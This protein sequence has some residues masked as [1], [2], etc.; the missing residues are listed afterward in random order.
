MSQSFYTRLARRYAP[1]RFAV[2]RRDLLKATLAASAG[3]LLS[4][5]NASNGPTIPW[6][7]R[8]VI[9]IGAGFAGLACAYELASVGY[10]VTVLEARNR[11]G[12][13]VLSFTDMVKG[14]VVEGGGELIGTNH[15]TWVNYEAKFHL[16]FTEIPD[17]KDAE[18]PLLLEGRLLA[19]DE[20]KKIFDEIDAAMSTLNDAARRVNE[21]QPWKT[22]NA[23]A[24]DAMSMVDWLAGVQASPLTKRAI[25]AELEANESVSLD[26]Q[27]YLAFLAM[28]KGGGV[29]KYWTDSETCRCTLGNQALAKALADKLTFMRVHLGTPIES[30][31]HGP[32]GVTV[33]T[34]DGDVY[35]ADDAVLTVPPTLWG[36]IHFTPELAHGFSPQMGTA[37]KYL[38]AVKERYWERSKLSA[39]SLSDNDASMTWE[40]TSGQKGEQGA[41]LTCF[42]GGPAAE[43][44]RSRPPTERKSFYESHLS[45]L[46]PGYSDNV[47]ATRFMD[48]PGDPWTLAGYSFAAPRQV[49]A[50][51]PTLY[52]GI[53]RLHFAGEY[54]SYK[55]CG[56]MEG[57]LN[58][59]VALARRIARRDNVV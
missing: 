33:T 17:D 20:A 36:K 35:R 50:F 18:E 5:C 48:W 1:E 2:S 24:L 29:E 21:D 53:D 31:A 6:L 32:S 16:G 44:A 25:R 37:V 58:S 19:K 14:K 43:N 12:G 39:D 9:V 10:D 55:F 7:N 11:V 13:R 45:K 28:V 54:T 27:S 34:T 57:G 56:Y 47:G 4:N 41:E 23:E 22:P 42:S 59:G 15:P 38:S 49:M 30:I 26:R 3:L 51:G 8:R 46:Y 52:N 40:G